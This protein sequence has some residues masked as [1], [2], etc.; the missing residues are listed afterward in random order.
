[1]NKLLK[2]EKS[3]IRERMKKSGD[4]GAEEGVKIAKEFLIKVKDRVKGVYL[5]PPF[6][7]FEMATN[8]LEVLK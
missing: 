8:I 5:M 4:K 1:M 6:N 2:I 3:I 7:E